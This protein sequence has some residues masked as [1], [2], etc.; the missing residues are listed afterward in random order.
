MPFI[1]D[2]SNSDWV[3]ATYPFAGA[4]LD[5][6]LP[7]HQCSGPFLLSGVDGREFGSLIRWPGFIQSTI[8]DVPITGDPAPKY[9][10]RINLNKGSEG[11]ELR[12]FVILRR[13]VIFSYYDSELRAWYAKVLRYNFGGLQLNSDSFRASSSN[14]ALYLSWCGQ[15][16]GSGESDAGQRHLRVSSSDFFKAGDTIW[17]ERDTDRA[18][19][20]VVDSYTGTEYKT[21]DG[22]GGWLTDYDILLRTNLKYTHGSSGATY[23]IEGGSGN[24]GMTVVTHDGDDF[25][26]EQAG[27]LYED[28]EVDF[29][30]NMIG[31][32]TTPAPTTTT[33]TEDFSTGTPTINQTYGEDTELSGTVA[34]TDATGVTGVEIQTQSDHG[35]GWSSFHWGSDIGQSMTIYAESDHTWSRAARNE[36]S[37][38][39]GVKYRVRTRL[40]DVGDGTPGPWTYSNEVTTLAAP[41]DPL[42]ELC[43]ILGDL[44]AGQTELAVSFPGSTPASGAQAQPVIQSEDG[45]HWTGL[46]SF[47]SITPGLNVLTVA[48]LQ[49]GRIYSVRHRNSSS[50]EWSGSSSGDDG[51]LISISQTASKEYSTLASINEPVSVAGGKINGFIIDGGSQTVAQITRWNG[52]R[53]HIVGK[54]MSTGQYGPATFEFDLPS[55]ISAGDIVSIR[56]R[57]VNGGAWSGDLYG[58]DMDENNRLMDISVV[59]QA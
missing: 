57:L 31:G 12:G 40:A 37:I 19:E 15:T 35:E 13:H 7:P 11:H 46:T 29:E 48:A 33:T 42:P 3:K 45:D 51:R 28:G 38:R 18:E 22:D 43:T 53:W 58:D 17:I 49:E 47:Q 59:V 36:T 52:E 5:K 26:I 34:A 55:S 6:S 21:P 56:T 1:S 14:V 25:L 27:P 9:I 24:V 10:T 50:G 2:D 39:E 32:T 8:G 16:T 23:Q 20:A 44:V 4:S 30:V 41:P 54:T